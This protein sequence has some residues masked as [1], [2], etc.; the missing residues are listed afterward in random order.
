MVED[1]FAFHKIMN[2]RRKMLEIRMA[3]TQEVC[4]FTAHQTTCH[5]NA[6]YAKLTTYLRKYGTCTDVQKL[7]TMFTKRPI[8]DRTPT[9]QFHALRVEFG[10]MPDTLTHLR[11]IF[12]NRFAPHIAG[13]LAAEKIVDIDG[14]ADRASELYII[15]DNSCQDS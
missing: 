3:L 2:N 11:H 1:A 10:T 6:D 9:E 4:T 7:R 5:T 14:Y 8:G 12:E 13:L 15:Y